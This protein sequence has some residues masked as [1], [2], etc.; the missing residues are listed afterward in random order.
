MKLYLSDKQLSVVSCQLS[1]VKQAKWEYLVKRDSIY[2]Q[3]FK[4]F[5][6]LIFELV[7]YRPEQAHNYRFESVEVK[8]TAFRIRANKGLPGCKS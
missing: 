4:Q 5:P 6:G 8:E 3:I 1:V 2:Y 7:D